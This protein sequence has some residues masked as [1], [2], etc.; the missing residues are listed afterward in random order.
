LEVPGVGKALSVAVSW[1]HV[2]LFV[3]PSGLVAEPSELLVRDL[4]EA[5]ERRRMTTTGLRITGPSPADIYLVADVQAQPYFLR[6]DVQRAV[7][8]AVAGYLAFDAVGFGQPVYLSRIYDAVQSL[9]EVA[10]LNV[11][12]FSRSPT[13][14]IGTDGTI[15]LAPNE[16]P[17]PG[18]RDNPDTLYDP[19]DPTYRPSIVARVKGGV[20]P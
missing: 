11:T 19:L 2:V 17:R 8:R 20:G 3:A 4:L 12:R 5:F 1:N 6:A 14:G 13:G 10:S 7:E 9:P 18:Y 15:E 16:L